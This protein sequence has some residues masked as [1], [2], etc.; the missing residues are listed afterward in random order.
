MS[1]VQAQCY[2]KQ[3]ELETAERAYQRVVVAVPA[4]VEATIGLSD[5]YR[6]NEMVDD[7][8][9]VLANHPFLQVAI[10]P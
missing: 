10:R 7:A 2:H 6:A 1:A 4:N 8:L 3:Q 9:A 5:V